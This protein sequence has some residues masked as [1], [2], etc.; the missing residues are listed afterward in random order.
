MNYKGLI[1]VFAS[2]MLLFAVSCDKEEDPIDATGISLDK[3]TL[4]IEMESSTALVATL[5]PSG[6]EGTITWSSS[7]PSVAAVA[8]GIVTAIKVGEATI[9][10][11]HGAFTASCAVTVTPKTIDPNDLPASLKGS[12]YYIIHI[13]ET[14]AAFIEDKIIEDFRVDDV[15][16]FLYVWDNT[17]IGNTTNG[18]NSYGLAEEW[19][20]FT[21]GAI[22]WSGAGYNVQPG[23]GMIDMTN[24]Y[25]NPDDYVFHVALKSAQSNTAYSFIFTDGISEAR[26]VIGDVPIEGVN[27]YMDFARDNEWHEIEIPVSYLRSLGVFYSETF[28]DVNILAFLAGGVQ[29]TTLDMDAAFFYKKAE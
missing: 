26:V 24:L 12:D 25:N 7:D 3:T 11:S 5:E 23:Y 10:A 22:G 13:D 1:L 20:S 17:F 2:L 19:I 4:E 16:K 28:T 14:S 29:G 8:N 21:V 15:N 9:A 6:A 27:P 18:L